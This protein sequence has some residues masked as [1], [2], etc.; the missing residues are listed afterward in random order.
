MRTRAAAAA[1][2]VVPKATQPMLAALPWDAPP[3]SLPAR[4]CISR[5]PSVAL[6]K[7]VGVSP[8]SLSSC[9]T[10]AL[11]LRLSAA[12]MTTASST[13]RTAVSI[14]GAPVT[15]CRNLLPM[16]LPAGSTKPRNSMPVSSTCG[17]AR[18]R[19]RAS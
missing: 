11:L 17:G 1:P 14:W 15:S 8:R 19:G 10:N 18:G 16:L 13:L 12:A 4:T 3:D 5:M 9:S 2:P 7:R 6:P